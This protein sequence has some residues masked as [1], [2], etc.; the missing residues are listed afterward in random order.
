VS[1]E[2]IILVCG[3]RLWEDR[4]LVWSILDDVTEG[5]YWHN[6]FIIEGGAKG[7]D[8]CG[9][10]WA[11]M[12]GCGHKT[13][14]ADWER[15]GKAAGP[16]RN[17]EMLEIGQPELVLAFHSDIEKSKGTKDM[18]QRANKAGIEVRLYGAREE[19]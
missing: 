7:A 16:I 17:S 19:S 12:I 13:Y 10:E 1:K 15:Y 14:S 2:F 3:D 5:N 11:K 18:I 8:T 4:Q 6:T 9:R